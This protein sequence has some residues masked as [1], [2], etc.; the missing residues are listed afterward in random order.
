[1]LNRRE[2]FR[3]AAAGSA[4]LV[5]PSLTR[6]DDAKGFAL[7]KLPY[8]FD[9]LEPVVDAKTMEIHHG[10]HH[11]AYVDNL[12]KALAGKPDLLAKPIVELVRD[13]KKLPADLQAPVRNNGGGHLN[14]TWFWQMMKKDGGAPKGELAKA[15]DA[16]FGS[17]DGFKKEF[18]TAA[19]TQFGSGWAWLVKGKEKPLA[20]VK[21]PNQDN[22]VTDGQAVLLGCDVWEHAYYLKYQN[23]RADYVNAWF[24]VVNWDFVAELFAAK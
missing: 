3:S 16:S 4:A 1:M 24:S 15:I 23:K 9:A 19:T 10:K 5:L 12:N 17:L 13:W 6:A 14:H 18:A 8:A 21:T 7:P 22:P 11:Q 2:L 20:V